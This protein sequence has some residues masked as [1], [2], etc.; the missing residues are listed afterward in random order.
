[1]GVG[2]A[3]VVLTTTTGAAVVGTMVGAAVV[4][5]AVGTAVGTGVATGAC[6]DVHPASRI[7]VNRIARTTSN[8]FMH[9]FWLFRYISIFNFFGD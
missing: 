7:P 4:T 5:T 8:F 3:T 6:W 2:V 1:V 9:V